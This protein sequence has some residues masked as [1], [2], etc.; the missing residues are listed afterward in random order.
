[1]IEKK[2]DEKQKPD[3]IQN[4]KNEVKI[5]PKLTKQ[6]KKAKGGYESEPEKSTDS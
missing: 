2:S 6:Q 4:S 1:M 3:E 5:T